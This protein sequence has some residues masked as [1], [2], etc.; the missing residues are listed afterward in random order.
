MCYEHSLAAIINNNYSDIQ[1]VTNT[2]VNKLNLIIV[3]TK[4]RFNYVN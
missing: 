1:I 3:N 2:F 4:V